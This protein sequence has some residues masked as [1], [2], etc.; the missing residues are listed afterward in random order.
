MRSSPLSVQMVGFPKSGFTDIKWKLFQAL[1]VSM[2]TRVRA[3]KRSINSNL[4]NLDEVRGQL[5]R[6]DRQA[7]RSASS[8]VQRVQRN[9]TDQQEKLDFVLERLAFHKN[10]KKLLKAEIKELKARLR[11]AR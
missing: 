1:E 3:V 2:G 8:R 7:N 11:R 4:S 5:G 10:E 9:L 6:V